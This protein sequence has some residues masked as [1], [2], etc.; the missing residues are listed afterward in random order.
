M[1]PTP[2]LLLALLLCLLAA[3][4]PAGAAPPAPGPA[5]LRA[6]EGIAEYRLANGL[7]VLLAPDDS[8]PS[9]TVNLTVRVGSRHEN[10]G[11][12][13]M[14]HLL[15]HMMFKGSPTTRN[16]WA[17]F[18][19]R[20]LQANGTTWLDR[21]NYFASFAANEDNLRWYI[22]WLAD[23]LVNSRVSRQDLDS[24]MTVVR[25][26]MEM[27][28]NSPERMLFEKTMA[29][30]YQWHNY[31]KS[32]IGARTDVENVDI[33]RL[34][35]FYRTYY[36]PDNATLI[37][38]G[39]F[40]REQ[41]LAW[42]QQTF[43]KLP[44]P[45]RKL[46]ALYT[47]D[48]VQ[49]GER[50]VTLR[51]VGGNPSAMVGYHIPAGAHP[52]YALVELL[53]LVLADA[54]SGRI[55]RKLVETGRAAATG[56]DVMALADPGFM[57]V[58]LQFAPGQSADAALPDLLA[59][60]EGLGS[61]PVT[62]EEFKRAQAKWLKG[63][64]QQFTDPEAVG[65]ALSESIALG[66]WRMFFLQRDR[67]RDASLA[68]L[69]RVARERFVAANRT[70]GL[71]LPTD[72]PLR[73]PADA[74]VDVSAQMAGFKP[75]PAAEKVPAFDTSPANLDRQTSLGSLPS[76]L[77]LALLPK[78]T[79]GQA[80][81]VVLRLHF[82]DL[83]SLKG[84]AQ[85][86]ALT[87]ALLDKGSAQLSRQQVQDRLNAL[88]TEM[89]ISGSADGV[90]VSLLTRRDHVAEAVAL[91]GQV[92][93]T[94]A[95]PEAAFEEVRRQALAGLQAERDDPEAL[96]NNHL[97]RR[98]NPYAA[99]DPRYVASFE[100]REQ[101]LRGATVDQLKA[102]HQRF[103]G[104][105]AGEFAAVGDFDAA[106]LKQAV[107]A[108]LGDWR[109]PVAYRRIERPLFERT[110][111]REQIRT[112]DKQNANLGLRLAVPLTDNDADYP[113]FYLA[114]FLLGAGGDSRLWKRVR[115]KEGLSYA[116]WSGVNWGQQE[117]H[118]LWYA[119]AIFAPA[120]R[121]KVERAVAEEIDRALK[122]GFSAAEV[123]AGRQAL[124]NFR[125]LSRAQDANLAGALVANLE[126]KRSFAR[127]Q[128]VDE[129]I[130]KATPEQVNAA[131][132]KYLK[133]AAMAA[134]VAGD[135]KP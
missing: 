47:L 70:L 9:T 19:K 34:Q 102:F 14:A 99:D 43:G 60:I 44:R 42:V 3:A 40:K 30:M 23:A 24:E 127:A 101:Q 1:H 69:N 4:A 63:W 61:Q 123:E 91:V 59:T 122:D 52:D 39:R 6:V 84:Q 41:V 113:H 68:D 121:E 55:H 16:P 65:V 51:R 25:N 97:G 88:K 12:T 54:P 53:G 38:S 79:R 80:V 118:S 115:E 67:V 10:Y 100:E 133:P 85:L 81:N 71:Y 21:T 46:P 110:A 134:A 112:P 75:Q 120:N 103:Y 106:A 96:V 82:G 57:L 5:E 131:L 49:D 11:E 108:A 104:A 135:F 13:G 119:G 116:V 90:T 130:A 26:E 31:G 128:Q 64:E 62:E 105:S 2:R 45:K 50:G 114:N 33:P 126:L 66:D 56:A 109:S 74:P 8:K 124:L 83:A 36:Q 17:E 7:Q 129:A 72:K 28:E 86:A 93:R 94:P 32:T 22:G 98:G 87:A 48:P 77:Q 92:L 95:F 132:R 117:P 76:G 18:N 125:R 89:S 35:A 27:G 111:G 20:G 15:E 107:Q 37:V 29:T 73:A 78:P 58:S